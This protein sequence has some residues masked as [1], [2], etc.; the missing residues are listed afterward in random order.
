VKMYDVLSNGMTWHINTETVWEFMYT[1]AL[2]MGTEL[3]DHAYTI[4]M[5]VPPH[6]E[7]CVTF[8]NLP[9]LSCFPCKDGTDI[10]VRDTIFN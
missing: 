1:L 4:N 2:N 7:H 9:V 10:F 8:K 3:T 5:H 6:L